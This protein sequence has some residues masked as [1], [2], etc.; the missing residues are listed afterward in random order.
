MAKERLTAKRILA[1]VVLTAL[2]TV[3]ACALYFGLVLTTTAF[4]PNSLI[5]RMFAIL[6][7]C[8]LYVSAIAWVVL[9]LKRREAIYTVINIVGA[10]LI[11]ETISLVILGKRWLF[12][13]SLVGGAIML[14]S[15]H[16]YR[17][18]L[19]E[20]EKSVDKRK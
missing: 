10:T 15:L 14:V 18:K 16:L 3:L 11:G 8:V 5:S 6:Y 9:R 17:K 4:F 20:E 19:A 1:I 2:A 13:V 12:F 7:P